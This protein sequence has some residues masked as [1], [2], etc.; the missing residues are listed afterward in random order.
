MIL[1]TAAEN[2]RAEIEDISS[3]FSSSSF[4]S[5]V[6]RGREA[7]SKR[8]RLLV[9]PLPPRKILNLG[10]PA[11]SS[12]LLLS[13]S[14][15]TLPAELLSF[16]RPQALR[17]FSRLLSTPTSP[18]PPEKAYYVTTP[19]FYVNASTPSVHPSLAP[20]TRLQTRT[21]GTSTRPS[22]PIST[23]AS[24]SCDTPTRRNR[25]CAREQTSM[26]SRSSA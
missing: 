19:I 12:M 26:G 20:L 10:S 15:L 23:R 11:C 22:S 18:P 24:P 16:A 3:S 9:S 5:R 1:R 6:A 13:R 8:S 14:A 2:S 4:E 25:S 21:S 7:S 17:P